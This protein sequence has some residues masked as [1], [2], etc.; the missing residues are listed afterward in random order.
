MTVPLGE[1]RRATVIG[2]DGTVH[3]KLVDDTGAPHWL[4]P[5]QIRV[6]I[7]DGAEVF[8]E[9]FQQGWRVVALAPKARGAKK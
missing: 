7:K 3:I 2:P 4:M 6:E 8:I 9:K 5:R 1:K